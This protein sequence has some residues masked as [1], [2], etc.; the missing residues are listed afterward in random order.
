MKKILTLVLILFLSSA[1]FNSCK[2]DKGE[3]PELPPQE[4]MTIDFSNFTTTKKSPD[5]KGTEDSNWEFAATVA[6][7]WNTI[8]TTNLA[9]P[10]AVFRLA[11][12]QD[13][14]YLSENNWQWSYS[15]N[16]GGSTYKARLTGQISTNEVIWTMYISKEGD[17]PEFTW[18]EGTSK[19]DGTS[20]EW[21]LNESY[22]NQQPIVTIVWTQTSASEKSVKYTY[23][24]SGSFQNSYIEYGL[25]SSSSYDAYYTIHYYNDVKF[26]DVDVE[27]NTS[28]HEGRVSSVDYL[29]DSDW[30]CWDSNK[31]NITCP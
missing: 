9:V 13:P 8:I 26:S 11:I 2:K 7:I 23:V 28:T 17:F 31:I 5:T 25:T 21:T 30:Y 12:D 27:W 4:C 22:Q 24:K 20:G 10:V 1:M 29:G 6:T 19:L 14:E 15:V 18:F 16:T 3:P